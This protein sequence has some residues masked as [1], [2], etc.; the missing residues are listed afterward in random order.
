[1]EESGSAF[2]IVPVGTRRNLSCVVYVWFEKCSHALAYLARLFEHLLVRL[3]L[4]STAL[5]LLK[6]RSDRDRHLKRLRNPEFAVT[7]SRK[8]EGLSVL[9]FSIV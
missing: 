6:L 5:A 2:I 1:M 7:K 9:G 3:A 8:R 4:T